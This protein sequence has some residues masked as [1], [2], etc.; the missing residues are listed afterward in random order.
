MSD[1]KFNGQNFFQKNY[2]KLKKNLKLH[3]DFITI[4][5]LNNFA[6]IVG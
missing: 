4:T 1:D 2:L 3:N 5:F 6:K